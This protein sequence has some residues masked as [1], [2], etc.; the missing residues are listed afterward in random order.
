MKKQT[1]CNSFLVF[2]LKKSDKH[3]DFSILKV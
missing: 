1:Y 3:A 2:S